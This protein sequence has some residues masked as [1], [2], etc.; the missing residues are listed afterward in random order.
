M[1]VVL[2]LS[3]LYLSQFFLANLHVELLCVLLKGEL[4]KDPDQLD[5]LRSL[6]SK[7]QLSYERKM[8]VQSSLIYS[9]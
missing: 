6:C 8:S 7:T 5:L 2:T 9:L 3:F 1:L 4:C